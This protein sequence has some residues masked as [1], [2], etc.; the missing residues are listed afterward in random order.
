[1]FFLLW[2]EQ[3]SLRYLLAADFGIYNAMLKCMVG[4]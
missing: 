2:V 1:M 3:N 4:D